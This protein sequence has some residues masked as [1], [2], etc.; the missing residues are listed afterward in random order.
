MENEI[1]LGKYQH[2]K[3]DEYT[4][5]SVAIHS[6]TGE[7]LVIYRAEYGDHQIWARPKANFVQDVQI[8]ESTVSRFRYLQTD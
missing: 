4:V 6:E 1:K 8:G 7:A 5:L 3:G 2:F